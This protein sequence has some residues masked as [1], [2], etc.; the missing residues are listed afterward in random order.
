[1]CDRY[2]LFDLKPSFYYAQ[3][4]AADKRGSETL[5]TDGENKPVEIVEE[6][7]PS[8][9]RKLS[10]KCKVEIS[11][12]EFLLLFSFLCLGCYKKCGGCCQTTTF[13]Y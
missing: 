4:K 12:L 2:S 5:A 7:P 13:R 10:F 11:L 1:L 6:S 9:T 8:V 3:N